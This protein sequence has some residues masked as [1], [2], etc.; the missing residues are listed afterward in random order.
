MPMPEIRPLLV[1]ELTTP[2]W[3]PLPNQDLPVFAFLI[4]H[5][6][7]PILIDTG[8]GIGND[9]IDREYRPRHHDLVAQLASEGVSPADLVAVAN[10]HLHFDHAGNNRAFEGTP[11]YVQ[12]AE[13]EAS[14]A[15]RYTIPGWIAHDDLDYRLIDG[16]H[17]P[18]S[19]VRLLSTPGHTP[20]HQ[21]V[22]VDT[23]LGLEAV[24]AQAAEDIEDFTARAATD[25]SLARI[26]GAAPVRLWFSH[27]PPSSW[28]R[29][30]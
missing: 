14:R 21:S 22:L 6:A 24:V 13:F 5:D 3:H 20:G 11:T 26:I 7:G 9:F 17:D 4:L 1:T 30:G 16:D 15:P 27:G 28:P 23:A 19:G 12:R 10:S 8:V 25:P 2:E 18:A 29:S